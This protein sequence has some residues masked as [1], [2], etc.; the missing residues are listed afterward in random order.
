MPCFCQIYSELPPFKLQAV[1]K[2]PLFFAAQLH[3][4]KAFI[5]ERHVQYIES[6]RET[7]AA[8]KGQPLTLATQHRLRWENEVQRE[9]SF[10]S[11]IWGIFVLRLFHLDWITSR[12]VELQWTDCLSY[13]IL[14][15]LAALIY[16]WTSINRLLTQMDVMWLGSKYF[17]HFIQHTVLPALHSSSC[18]F[19]ILTIVQ[20]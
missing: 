7:Y 4:A 6:E 15:M 11:A 12:L 2:L 3:W 17:L 20:K 19:R 9:H 14:L 1:Q 5:T 16:M 8:R 18:T 13:T 10:L